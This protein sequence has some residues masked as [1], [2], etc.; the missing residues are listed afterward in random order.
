M[1]AAG[2]EMIVDSKKA[3]QVCKQSLYC[4]RRV[5][6]HSYHEILFER[7]EIRDRAV[8]IIANFINNAL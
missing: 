6:E 8:D 7:D 3:E 2:M 1:L 5:F 4:D